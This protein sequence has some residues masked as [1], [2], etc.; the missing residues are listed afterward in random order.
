MLEADT[1]GDGPV[2]HVDLVV[3]VVGTGL[4][5]TAAVLE[6]M[7]VGARGGRRHV[8]DQRQAGRLLTHRFLQVAVAHADFLG[9]RAG[10]EDPRQPWL[11]GEGV[12]VARVRRQ[13]L[14]VTRGDG[15]AAEAVGVV[16]QHFELGGVVE[17]AL[18]LERHVLAPAGEVVVVAQRLVRVAVVL[19][20]GQATGHVGTAIVVMEVEPE[21]VNVGR[22]P[23][24][25]EDDV[26][27][28]VAVVAFTVT[29]AIHP[30]VQQRHA[31]AVI[32]RAADEGRLGVFP[33]TML[34]GFQGGGQ[35]GRG[36]LRD[37]PGN[38]VDHPADVLRAIAHG[39]GATHHVDAVEVAR[40]NRRHRQLRLAIGREGGRDAVD[41]HRGA[42]RQARSQPANTHVQRQV[43]AAGAVGVLHLHTRDAAQD[44]AHVHRALLHHRLAA[45]HGARAGVVLHHALLGIAQPVTHHLDVGG[46]QL[47]AAGGEG[48]IGLGRLDHHGALGHLV[49]QA[50]ALQQLLQRLLGRQLAGHR[51]GLLAGHQLGAEEQLQVGLLAQLVQRRSQ[52]LGLDLD[53]AAGLCGLAVDGHGADRQGQRQGA[54]AWE[55]LVVVHVVETS[56]NTE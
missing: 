6:H 15:A 13:G 21:L 14:H 35:L 56:W 24:G 34:G 5:T 1:W 10:E 26:V 33:A 39:T 48:A 55:G 36:L 27:D 28:V 44:V 12:V 7:A 16:G 30:G 40:G 11:D 23:V 9:G 47:Q 43:A 8:V 22:R 20:L 37:R 17:L 3:D 51:R 32:R 45:H 2:T 18:P 25:L 46:R 19:G 42:W 41:Q 4:G 50:A 53:G 31:H 52:G 54:E 29:V 38:E 49:G